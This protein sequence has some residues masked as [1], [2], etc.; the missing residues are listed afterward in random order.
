MKCRELTAGLT[1]IL[2]FV[3]I[4]DVSCGIALTSRYGAIPAGDIQLY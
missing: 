1:R 2:V 3:P 4:L